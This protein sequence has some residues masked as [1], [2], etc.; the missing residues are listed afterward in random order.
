MGWRGDLVTVLLAAW[1]I[2]GLFIDGWAH[3]TRPQLETFFTPWHAVFYSGF[4]ATAAWMCWSVWVRR[5]VTGPWRTAVPAGYGLGLAG[6]A[7]FLVSG[8]G[9]LSWH[10][11]FGI[12]RDIAALLSPTHLGLF[13][14][15]F[16]IVTTPLRSA[17]ANPGL[18]RRVGLGRLLPAVVSLTLAGSLAAFMFQD[19]H[20]M[21]ENLTS[22]GDQLGLRERF[23]AF[24]YQDVYRLTIEAG[25]PG[26]MLATAFLFGP[27]LFLVRRWRPP[28]GSALIVLGTQSLLVQAL[29]GFADPGLAVLGVLGAV[30][31]EA[32]LAGV[33]PSPT[34]RWRLRGFC[35]VAPVVFWG[36]YF[37]GIGLHDGGLGWK[38]EIWGGTLVWSGLTLLALAMVMFPPRRAAGDG[39]DMTQSENKAL[40]A[41]YFD[42]VLTRGHVAALDDL[43]APGFRSWLPDGSSV[44]AGPTATRCW[45]R[46]RPSPTLPPLC[47][48][49]SPRET[50]WRPAGR[51]EAPIVVRSPACRPPGGRSRSPP[52]TS[53]ASSAAGS[54][55]TGRP[56]ISCRCCTNSASLADTGYEP[57]R[58][59]ASPQPGQGPP[60]TSRSDAVTMEYGSSWIFE[61]CMSSANALWRVQ[62]PGS[63]WVTGRR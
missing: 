29:T 35:A 9:D 62:R 30:A 6:L 56:S 21:Y 12:E 2:A 23:S 26:F 44:G 19:L 55:S 49:R 36:V 58:H 50:G 27:L 18:G 45:P 3:T 20:P 5:P 41:R 7:L 15:A 53:T 1:L 13:A 46:G 61:P 39:G 48:T 37:G 16:L 51:R 32:L 63:S 25:V 17:W 38:A 28:V 34:P 8:L 52:S 54:P 33:R 14:G 40:V 11:A 47:W 4:A 24:Q 31:V 22:I 60:D 57:S 59:R 43:L 42:Q 10:L